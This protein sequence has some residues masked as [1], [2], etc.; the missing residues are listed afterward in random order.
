MGITKIHYSK[1]NCNG[2]KNFNNQNPA[3]GFV[4]NGDRCKLLIAASS[5]SLEDVSLIIFEV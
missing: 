1:D 3:A 4:T 2:S 5:K